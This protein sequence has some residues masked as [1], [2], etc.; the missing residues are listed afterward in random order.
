[1]YMLK[2]VS[3]KDKVQWALEDVRQLDKVRGT[4]KYGTEGRGDYQ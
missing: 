4:N 3:I 1:M 2:N